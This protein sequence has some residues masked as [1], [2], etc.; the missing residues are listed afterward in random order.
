MGRRLVGMVLPSQGTLR[1]FNAEVLAKVFVAGGVKKFFVRSDGEPAIVALQE[2]V[3]TERIASGLGTILSNGST[4][5]NSG[6]ASASGSGSFLLHRKKMF[7]DNI[8]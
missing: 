1:A 5:G 6:A 2:R 8:F 4:K 7:V 3:H